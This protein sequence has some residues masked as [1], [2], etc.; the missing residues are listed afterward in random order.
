[1]DNAQSFSV[2]FPAG[3]FKD[4]MARSVGLDIA[5][6]FGAANGVLQVSVCNEGICAEGAVDIS[7]ATDNAVV[8]I[9]LDRPIAIH[10]GRPVTLTANYTRASHRMA[11]WLWPAQSPPRVTFAS[12]GTAQ[13]GLA[14]LV[15][16]RF[17]ADG[18]KPAL[19]YHDETTDIYQLADPEDYFSTLA[20]HCRLRPV[21]RTEVSA[22]CTTADT[23]VR[24]ELFFP[25]WTA[26]ADITPYDTIFQ[27]VKL[28]QGDQVI[29]FT[30]Q[31]PGIVWGYGAML[32][33]LLALAG[34][35][36]RRTML[37]YQSGMGT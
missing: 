6:Y 24:R 33:G 28:H 16:L 21:S 9:A 26:N 25:G 2:T 1:L 34:G 7:G 37:R 12:S 30:Y 14:P 4:G 5:T 18:P 8:W 36:A 32:L 15:A 31:P 23:L 19:V 3:E 17:E 13:A 20:G 10:A 35:P 29:H 22:N 11:V 27:S